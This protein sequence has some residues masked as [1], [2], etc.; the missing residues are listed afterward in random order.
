MKILITD[1][2]EHIKEASRFYG[3]GHH[4]YY[5][6]EYRLISIKERKRLNIQKLKY[7]VNYKIRER[8]RKDI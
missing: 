2:N 8:K 1:E 3:H 4:N 7:I 5:S 6:Q